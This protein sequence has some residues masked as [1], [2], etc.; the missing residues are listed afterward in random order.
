[1]SC[2]ERL[3][4]QQLYAVSLRRW[5]QIA[6][7]SQLFGQATYKRLSL[8]PQAGVVKLP[9]GLR[10]IL[11]LLGLS[12]TSSILLTYSLFFVAGSMYSLPVTLA[13]TI[14]S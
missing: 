9:L 11:H 4:L 1:M 14:D 10:P 13:M 12:S 2:D 7:S 6:A 5:A 8:R 3:S